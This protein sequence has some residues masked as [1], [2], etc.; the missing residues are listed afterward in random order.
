[1]VNGDRVRTGYDIVEK[2]TTK[3]IL[4]IDPGLDTGWALWRAGRLIACGHGDPR[5]SPLHVVHST[6]QDEDVI[7]DVWIE[8]QEI[9]PRSPVPP[10]DVLTLAKLA[11]STR[12][13]YET[14]GCT[15]HMVLPRAWKGQT[16]CTCTAK[17]PDP[18]ACTHHSR[19]WAALTVHEQNIAADVC[20]GMAPGK[21]HN[22]LDAIGI[23]QWVV[24]HAGVTPCH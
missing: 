21:R 6:K 8:D 4:S 12:G 24:K 23:G 22:V 15:V 9:Y 7:H 1:M 10:N 14:L 5:S 18:A 2:G 20:K 19:V 17:Q 16:P 11:H 13:R 3:V